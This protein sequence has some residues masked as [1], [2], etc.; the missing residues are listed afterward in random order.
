MLYPSIEFILLHMY[1]MHNN[2]PE[3]LFLINYVINYLD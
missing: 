3:N 2:C 1:F